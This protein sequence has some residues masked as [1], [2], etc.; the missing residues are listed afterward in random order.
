MSAPLEVDDL[1]VRF[2]SRAGSEPV[3]AVNGASF[4]IESGEIVGLV[5]ESGCG[6]SVTARSIVRLEEPGEIV[7]GSVRFDGR[8]L[9]TADDRTLRRLRARELATVFQDPS[10]S[11][12]PVYTVGEQIAEALRVRNEPDRQPLLRE[13]ARGASSR[14]RSR[15]LRSEVLD[16]METVGI[17]RPAERIDDYPHQF[18][19][20]MRQRA[21]L[22]IALARRP[23]VLI[24]DEPTT[25]LDTTT[26]AAILERLAAINEKRGMSVLLIS[27][28]LDVVS[29]LCDRLV[30]MYDGTV[31][32]RG[33]VDDLRSNP[34]HPYTKALLGCLPRRSRPG[35]RL[36]TIGGSPSDGSCP[37]NGCA[38]A[39]RCSFARDDCDSTPQPTVS[40]G[41]DHTV[42]CGVPDAREATIEGTPANAA[43]E[44]TPEATETATS[45]ETALA[46][47]G[48]T[49]A[50]T[51]GRVRQGDDPTT[52]EPIVELEAVE[53]SFRGSDALLD[54]LLGTDER[55]PAVDGVSLA[56]RPGETVGLVGES[57][58]GKSTLARVIAGLEE[59]TDGTVKLQGTAVGG[60]DARTDDQRAEIGVV[61]QH[62]GTSL[63]PKRTVEES[64]A[65]PLVE[66]GWT[67][68]RRADRVDELLSLVGLPL[69]Y[70]DRFPRQLSG[71]QRQRVAIARA[72]ALEPSVLVLD[73]PTAALDVS[74]QATILNLL[75]DL[76]DELG[77]ACLFV[78]HDVDVVRHVA[79][80]VAVMYL[81]RL[82]EVGQTE[83]TLSN[84]THPYTATL[85]A[86]L[87]GDRGDPVPTAVE[88]RDALAGDP[89]SP[90]DPPAGCAFHPRCPV[91]TEECRRREP[92]LESVGD[93]ASGPRSRCLY[94]PE[95]IE[96]G[97]DP[98]SDVDAPALGADDE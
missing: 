11:L 75:A 61:F 85:L 6:K 59:P 44:S 69:E 45:A 24:A 48:G 39:D 27:H 5:G 2:R 25:A 77:L 88:D 73:E 41:E 21:M 29:E 65:E 58:C 91:A 3:R 38:F 93:G 20:G 22:A 36:P 54:R 18:S 31:V 74:T 71:G 16:L 40:V 97:E 47:D 60:V 98:P 66:A 81:G 32:E 78:S 30:V 68:A 55:V 63:D 56:L 19:G 8:E 70:A 86:S 50:R 26:Q 23:S 96:A 92:P 4:R 37:Q 14:L 49:D 80:R 33:P 57:G 35:A 7:D 64:I 87:P 34:A 76:R 83:R 82:V 1:H 52:G 15:A 43:A 9:T 62:P 10:T 79:D 17:P 95:W 12:N 89:P 53:K 72:L 67:A 94:A 90:T 84:P 42:A 28:D 51:G 13:L 46:V